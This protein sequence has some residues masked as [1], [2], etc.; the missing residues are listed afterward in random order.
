MSPS[1]PGVS[2]T[3]VV[4]VAGACLLGLLGWRLGGAPERTTT[5]V[6]VPAVEMETSPLIVVH[7]TGAVARPGLVTVPDGARVA[8]VVKAAGGLLPGADVSGINLA[9]VVSDGQQLTV[10]AA[11]GPGTAPGG[12]DELVAIN[13]ATAEE[14]E[15]LPGVGPVLAERIIAHREE[16]GPFKVVEDLLE[17]TGI[18][19]RMLASLRDLVRV[20]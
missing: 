8:D 1:R 11:A 4:T 19:E 13:R 9:S 7:V 15:E 3:V 2:P 16:N 17:V 6:V 10:G 18:G 5:P 14:L 12:E 20:P